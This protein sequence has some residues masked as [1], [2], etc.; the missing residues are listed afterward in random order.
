MAVSAEST[1]PHSLFLSRARPPREGDDLSQWHFVRR[2]SRREQG[3]VAGTTA[4]V[5]SKGARLLRAAAARLW[6]ARRL[7]EEALHRPQI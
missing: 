3:G 7:L 1:D 4:L 2:S 5:P 6:W